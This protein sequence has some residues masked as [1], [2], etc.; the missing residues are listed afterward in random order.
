MT[1]SEP[2]NNDQHYSNVKG[3]VTSEKLIVDISQNY[4]ESVINR[5]LA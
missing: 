5:A 3:I 2:E 4:V 1:I